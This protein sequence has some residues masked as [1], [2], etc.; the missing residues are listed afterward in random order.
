MSLQIRPQ[1]IESRKIVGHL[2]GNDVYQIG[3]KGGLF[4]IATMRGLRMEV[5]GTGPHHVVAKSVARK[6]HPHLVITE[7]LK[8]EEMPEAHFSRIVP[9]YMDLTGQLNKLAQNG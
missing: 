9:Y 1:E 2:D 4:V 8:S 7:L 6:L 5:I 3:L